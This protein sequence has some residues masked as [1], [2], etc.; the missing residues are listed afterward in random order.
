MRCYQKNV[1]LCFG[2]FIYLILLYRCA[3]RNRSN[4]LDPH[5]PA[6]AGI[7]AGLRVYSLEQRVVVSWDDID[8]D[9]FKGMRIYR[10]SNQSTSF[11]EVAFV[12]KSITQFE[13]TTVTYD[14]TYTYRIQAETDTYLS[15]FSESQRITPGPSYIWATLSSSG[16]V[17]KLTHDASHLILSQ[18]GLYFPLGVAVV[19]YKKGVWVTDFYESK[20][21]RINDDG[22]ITT[23]ISGFLSPLDIDCNPNLNQLWVVDRDRKQVVLFDTTGTSIGFASGFLLPTF[24][25]AD[26]INGYFWIVDPSLNSI[27]RIDPK[28]MGVAQFANFYAPEDVKAVYQDG[29]CWVADSSRLVRLDASGN[30]LFYVNGFNHAVRVALN[31][32]TGDC[33]VTDR[34]AEP[35][36]SV[37]SKISAL[38]HPLFAVPGFSDPYSL[39]VDEY[40]GSCIVA[41]TWNYRI[42]KI[43]ATSNIIGEWSA[44]SPP[45]TVRVVSE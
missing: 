25:S 14:I 35:N 21:A 18:R 36:T 37:I 26:L 7:P 5:N 30:V 11:Q 28:T 4:P 1:L 27:G 17:V 23:L 9:G 33:W 38:G 2:V 3:E 10:S 8:V 32:K 22:N 16:E 42:V 39:D 45:R 12:N 40:D 6:T 24:G 20:I 44:S 15:P 13:D 41:D 19:G 43:S 29:G 34:L 31:Q